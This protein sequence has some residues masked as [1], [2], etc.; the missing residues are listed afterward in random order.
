MAQRSR[1][2]LEL[3]LATA[4]RFVLDAQRFP[5]RAPP[6]RPT[7][8]EILRLVEHLGYVQLDP[9]SIVARSHL[10]VLWS[11]LGPY[12]PRWVDELLEKDKQLFEYWAHE[13]SIVPT[14]DLPYHRF[15]MRRYPWE[16]GPYGVRIRR[17][18][19][20][21]APLRR[22]VLARLRS[23]G[24]L[25]LHAF[26]GRSPSGWTSR[27]RDTGRNVQ[28]ML[29][30][31][32]LQGRVAVPRRE[33]GRRWWD[34]AERHYPPEPKG[35]ALSHRAGALGTVDRALQALG[36][37]TE[38]QIAHYSMSNRFPHVGRV[39]E[40]LTSEGALTPT[41]L[42]GGRRPVKGRWFVR[43]K[44][45]P[46]L[47]SGEFDRP[48]RRATLLSPF[49]SL[50]TNRERTETLFGLRYR[51]EI[52]TP[53]AKRVH[54]YYAMPVLV[55]DRLV[56]T[57][58]P[59]FDRR[60]NVLQVPQGHESSEEAGERS[61]GAGVDRAVRGLADFLG[62]DRVEYGRRF[63]AAWRGHLVS[64]PLGRRPAR[65]SPVVT[66]RRRGGLAPG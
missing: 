20:R 65:A 22:E 46:R 61:S 24:A 23:D 15:L 54:G 42:T 25:P 1:T 55:G 41:T 27:E 45:L 43:T 56:G 50:I 60:R 40:R 9:T 18:M 13:A 4:R 29:F 51:I 32:W 10:L 37:A 66:P 30:V 62:A 63:P 21:N 28:Q 17:W 26:A 52:Y 53:A 6:R 47:T 35:G 14:S 58:E 44:D 38:R 11:R 64:G 3:P 49:D 16:R 31:L 5:K 2:S 59:V 33:S 34:L 19:K 12:D 48:W 39:I 7:K 36:V 8:G 57:V